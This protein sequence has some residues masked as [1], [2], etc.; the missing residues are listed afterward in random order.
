MKHAEII[1]HP[2][3]EIAK[4][5]Q[6]IFGGFIEHI[7]RCVYEGL[8]DPQS[9]FAGSDGFR[10]DVLETLK[11]LKFTAMRYPGGN[12]VSG[13]HWQDGV[14]PKDKRPS[15]RDIAWKSIEPNRFGTDEFLKICRLMNWQPMMAVN[16]G[17]A[18]PEEARD[19][20]E[21]CNCPAGTKYSDMRKENGSAEPYGVKLWCLGN[22]M[23]GK[24]QMGH[25]PA[26]DYA[27]RAQQAAKLMKDLDGSVELVVCGSCAP[28][29]PS[30]M[31]WDLEVLDYVD[32]FADY[33]SLHHYAGNT[34]GDSLDFLAVTNAI[35][36]QIEDMDAACRYIQALKKSDKRYYL[37]FDEWNIWY[38]AKN[39]DGGWQ[40][41]PHLLEE[42]YNMED[43]LVAAGFLNSF[44][45]HADSVKIANIAQL[46]NVIAPVLTSSDGLFTQTIY[47]S[48]R[49]FA[50]RRE[51]ISLKPAVKCRQYES[52]SYGMADII[53]T[54]AIIDGKKLNVF[55]VNRNDT[56]STEVEINICD[57][58]ISS[59]S[60]GEILHNSDLKAVNSFEEPDKICA[61]DFNE[62][63]IKDGRAKVEMPGFSFAALTFN[64]E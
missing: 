12:F 56:G 59:L 3:Y 19:W 29:M 43:A 22:E 11:P 14:G 64:L 57:R 34:T 6:R 32:E 38:R 41:A 55:I 26:K 7:G 24:W 30:Y 49:M 28:V 10:S 4:V 25:V 50:Q 47:H 37:A 60:S 48:I 31:Q 21:Y 18:A 44:I 51:G 45:R 52:K 9:K 63:V 40:L 13:Y 33:V 36:R 39:L 15:C 61:V 2:D 53:D 20:L 27:V 42:V 5:D 35:D 58:Q 8:Y 54:S 16:L 23:D 17:T 46:V 1:L 62:A